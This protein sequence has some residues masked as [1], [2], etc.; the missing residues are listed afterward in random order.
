MLL[1][2]HTPAFSP[3]LHFLAFSLR[4]EP[5]QPPKVSEDRWHLRPVS[6]QSRDGGVGEQGLGS[7]GLVEVWL[8]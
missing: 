3:L 6:R 8:L 7:V 1:L 2:G 5:L 4:F